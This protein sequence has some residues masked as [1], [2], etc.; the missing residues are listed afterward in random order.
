MTKRPVLFILLLGFAACIDAADDTDLADSDAFATSAEGAADGAAWQVADTL[1]AQAH[2]YDLAGANVRRVHSIWVDGSTAH[3]VSL[4]FSARANEG[5]DVRISVLGPI[6][7]GSRKVLGA[8]GYSSAKRSVSVTLPI[9][10]KGEHLVVVGS[11]NLAHDT[12]YRLSTTC[13]GCESKVD[14]LATPK[15]FALAG[16]SHGLVSMQLGTVMTGFGADV[17]VEV[18]ASPPMQEWAATKVATSYASGSQVNVIVPASVKAGDDLKLVVRQGTGRVLDSGIRVRYMP[19]RLALLRLDAILYGDLASLDIAG[20]VG[21]FEGQADMRLRSETRNKELARTVKRLEAPG[22]VGNGLN[23]VDM[24]FN[25]ALTNAAKDGERLSVGFING[26][27]TFT[28]MGCFEYC[29]NLS[30]MS[31]CTGG[32][33]AC[34]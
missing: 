20:V 31:S 32:P 7:N 15:D 14:I 1:H 30:G 26:A 22:Q 17:A 10:T 16:D 18:W 19:S 5:Q 13:T 11:Y 28:R 25:P 29:N 6:T 27:G 9:K 24:H 34:Q 21:F 4:T 2:L 8:D 3:P 23:A 33:R 12:F